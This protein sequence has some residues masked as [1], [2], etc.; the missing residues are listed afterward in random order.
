[1]LA[2][3]QEEDPEHTGPPAFHEFRAQLPTE[4]FNMRIASLAFL[5]LFSAVSA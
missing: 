4:K 5:E 2:N 3:K 1:M